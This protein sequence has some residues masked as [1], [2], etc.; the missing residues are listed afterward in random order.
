MHVK[1]ETVR[2]GPPEGPPVCR[3]GGGMKGGPR[4]SEAPQRIE[5]RHRGGRWGGGAG[6]HRQG[7]GFELQRIG[8]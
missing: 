4:V 3:E 5:G 1:L 7:L 2:G 8:L 6:E